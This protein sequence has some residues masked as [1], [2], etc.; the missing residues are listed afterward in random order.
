MKKVKRWTVA[1][2]V[3][4]MI[5]YAVFA[6]LAFTHNLSGNAFELEMQ[7]GIIALTSICVLAVELIDIVEERYDEAE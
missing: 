7:M 1:M 5:G 3:A 2:I 6:V 4:L